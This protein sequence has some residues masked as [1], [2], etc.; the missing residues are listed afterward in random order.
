[1]SKGIGAKLTVD[2]GDS[3]STGLTD[4]A[5]TSAVSLFMIPLFSNTCFNACSFRLGYFVFR[6]E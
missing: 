5:S 4:G 6:I 3:L 1:M 2:L